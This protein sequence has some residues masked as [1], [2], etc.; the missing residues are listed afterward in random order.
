MSLGPKGERGRDGLAVLRVSGPL[1]GL[2]GPCLTIRG[3]E[4]RLG[5]GRTTR[6]IFNSVVPELQP[7]IKGDTWICAYRGGAVGGGVT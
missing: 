4:T 1:G 3:V 6:K 7:P 5:E 2:G